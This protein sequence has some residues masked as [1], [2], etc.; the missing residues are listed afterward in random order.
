MNIFLY[1]LTQKMKYSWPQKSE[2]VYVYII[3]VCDTLSERR[4][5]P[6]SG[7]ISRS[8]VTRSMIWSSE[9]LGAL[10]D[11]LDLL[12]D[13]FNNVAKP[14]FSCLFIYSDWIVE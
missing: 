6:I 3:Y 2:Y 7:K 12:F 14:L 4:R 9:I 13:I 11:C 5:W 8:L 1:L 10:E